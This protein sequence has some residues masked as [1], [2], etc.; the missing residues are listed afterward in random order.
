MVDTAMEGDVDSSI[1]VQSIQALS[2]TSFVP[3]D[4][5]AAGR[6]RHD[7]HAHK[8]VAFPLSPKCTSVG[9]RLGSETFFWLYQLYAL[10]PGGR[11]R[12]CMPIMNIAL[13]AHRHFHRPLSQ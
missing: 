7:L 4:A 10:L 2:I 3:H 1:V 8:G 5:S 11:S 6:W 12:H 13:P 9:D